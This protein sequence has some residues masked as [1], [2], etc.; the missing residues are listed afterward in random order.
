MPL[1]RTLD[2]DT[3]LRHSTGTTTT[4]W[5]TGSFLGSLA[6]EQRPRVAGGGEIVGHDREGHRA[7][8]YS[9]G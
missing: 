4:F 6:R 9:K 8:Y 2:A 5:I 1:R 3:P 7:A